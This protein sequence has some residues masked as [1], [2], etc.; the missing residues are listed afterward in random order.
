[1]GSARTLPICRPSPRVSL[2]EQAHIPQ[3]PPPKIKTY[4]RGDR[5]SLI[6]ARSPDGLRGNLCRRLWRLGGLFHTDPGT[7]PS[8]PARGARLEG[9]DRAIFCRRL[10]QL[11]GA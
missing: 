8:S 1:M 3:T 11:R 7:Y 4:R 6:V 10:L 9:T 2:A 5:D